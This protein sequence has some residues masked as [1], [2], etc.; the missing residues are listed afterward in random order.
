MIFVDMTVT[1]IAGP[2]IGGFKGFGSPAL[3]ARWMGFAALLPFAR[4]HTEK[5]MVQLIT[6]K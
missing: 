1:A 5:G 3:F 6:V 2:D 4:A